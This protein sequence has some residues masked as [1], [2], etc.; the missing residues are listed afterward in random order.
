MVPV[1]IGL[2]AAAVAFLLDG[3]SGDESEERTDR[4]A[5]GG[6]RDGGIGDEGVARNRPPECGINED[7]FVNVEETISFPLEATDPDDDRL[8]FSSSG[9]PLGATLSPS[10]LFTWRPEHSQGGNF[11]IPFDV[12]DSEFMTSC[13]FEIHVTSVNQPPIMAS[14]P[15]Q[16]VREGELLSFNVSA[17][18]PDG[19]VVRLSSGPLPSGALFN[20]AS[21]LFS[22]TPGFD[23]MGTYRVEFEASDGTDTISQTV[24]ITVGNVNSQPPELEPIGNRSVNE[25]ERLEFA[26]RAHDGDG[27]SLTLRAEGLPTGASFDRA[28]GLFRWAPSFRQAGNYPV[29]FVVSDGMFEDSERIAITVNNVLA[30]V[31]GDGFREDQE[32]NDDDPSMRPLRE[33]EIN[34]ITTDTTVCPGL[35]RGANILIGTSGTPM[36]T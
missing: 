10:G 3:C 36:A 18:D 19:D 5:G 9:L 12:S 28:L 35:Y 16:T 29:T 22:W 23:Q 6:R 14:I 21:G 26:V 7:R 27:D 20:P 25:G 24:A 31:D 30:D 33:F 34:E 17:T 1:L 2:G 13:D 15:N 4:D 11:T 32:C 8:F